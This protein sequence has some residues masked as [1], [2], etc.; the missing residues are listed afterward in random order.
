MNDFRSGLVCIGCECCGPDD[1]H[2]F[3][4]EELGLLRGGSNQTSVHV[5]NGESTDLPSTQIN[6]KN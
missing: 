4:G 2:G 1:A 3:V 6:K 5:M